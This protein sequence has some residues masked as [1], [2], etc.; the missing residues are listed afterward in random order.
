MQNET[1]IS[2]EALFSIMT[3]VFDSM[4]QVGIQENNGS[5][6]ADASGRISLASVSITGGWSGVV[7]MQCPYELAS[8]LGQE[9]FKCDAATITAADIQ[10][11]MG[12]LINMV[13]GNV[14]AQMP[15]PS[16][17]SLPNVVQGCE[18]SWKVPGG[19]EVQRVHS[20]CKDKDLVVLVIQD[21]KQ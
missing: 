11:A 15:G 13:G 8:E 4:L 16:S 5:A 20:K 1:G 12:E 9:M 21:T 18:F 6:S 3:D 14:K 10:D 7:F 17:L 2:K 19:R